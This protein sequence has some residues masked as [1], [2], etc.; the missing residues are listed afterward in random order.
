MRL[1]PFDPYL[2]FFHLFRAIG[3]FM[4]HQDSD[5]M[6]S[7]RRAVANSPEF[8]NAVAWLAA[9]LALAG[10]EE[11]ARDTLKRY[12]LIRG[13][14]TRTIAQWKSLEYSDNPTYL[15]VIYPSRDRRGGSWYGK[16]SALAPRMS[17]AGPVPPPGSR[18][19]VEKG[20]IVFFRKLRFGF[21]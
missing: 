14:K 18:R 15:E 2:V 5:A 12:F 9:L 17:I 10:H 11:E 6:V 13:T 20:V 21:G 4:L 1:S 19:T 8:S 7:L 16:N 3:C